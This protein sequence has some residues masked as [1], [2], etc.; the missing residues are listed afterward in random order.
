MFIEANQGPITISNSTS[1]EN[2]NGSG[3]AG[4]NSTDVALMDS[5]LY[6]N[7]RA[8]VT[9][10][11]DYERSVMNWETARSATL[12]SER[13]KLKGNVILSIDPAQLLLTTPDWRPFVGSL[14]SDANI[15]YKPGDARGFKIGNALLDFGQWRS[16]ADVDANS[17]FSGQ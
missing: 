8:Q 3:I 13:W 15:W 14:S 11:G 16:T 4:A 17:S 12:R 6:G 1:C 10:T 9:I 5:V 2:R 7:S